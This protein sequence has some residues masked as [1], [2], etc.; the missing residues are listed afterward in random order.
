V[1]EGLPKTE[2]VKAGLGVV[3]TQRAA[4]CRRFAPRDPRG[5]TAGIMPSVSAQSTVI[6]GR[7]PKPTQI[8][9]GYAMAV[10]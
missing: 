10:H 6:P 1:R 4:C 5:A 3:A 2:S 7:L 8:D 9:Y